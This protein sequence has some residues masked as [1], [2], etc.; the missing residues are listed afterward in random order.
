[1]AK[2]EA[3]TQERLARACAHAGH[4]TGANGASARASLKEIHIAAVEE[5]VGLSEE[6]TAALRMQVGGRSSGGE[7]DDD[8]S[9]WR[10]RA[11]RTAR[12]DGGGEGLCTRA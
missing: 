5:Q 4:L 1:M 2:H 3:D 8:E 11:H 10:R 12:H 6:E 9:R 7:P